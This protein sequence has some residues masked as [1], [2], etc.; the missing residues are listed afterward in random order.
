MH[1]LQSG[2]AVTFKE[3]QGMTFLNGSTQEIRGKLTLS[4]NSR[5]IK[6]LWFTNIVFLSSN[7]PIFRF[8]SRGRVQICRDC[9]IRIFI[10]S[11]EV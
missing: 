9:K 8:Q 5:Y 7:G 3:I 4:G 2:D 6:K 11:F 10:W 1:G